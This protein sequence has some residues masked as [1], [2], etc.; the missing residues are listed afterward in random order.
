[1]KNTGS[2]RWSRLDNAAKIFPANSRA[3]DSKVFRFFCELREPV[4]PLA[5]QSALDGTVRE[6]PFYCSVMKR[7]LFWNYLEESL[8]RPAVSEENTPPCLSLYYPD[9]KGLLF[10]VSYYGKRI[11]LEIY[12]VLTDGTGALQFLCTLVHRYLLEKHAGDF[13]GVPPKLAYT[14]SQSQLWDD[15]F[16]K[17]YEKPPLSKPSLTRSAYHLRGERQ[18]EDR[19]SVVE[20][21]MP[22]DALLALARSRGATLTEFLTAVLIRAIYGQMRLRDRGRPVVI[23]VPV[24]LRNFLPSES[25][26][27]FFTTISVDYDFSRR[28]EKLDA[29]V[30]HVHKSFREKL[31]E[32]RLHERV[33]ML[34]FLEHNIPLRLVPLLLKD[35]VLFAAARLADRQATASFSNVGKVT[36][37]EE[38]APYI[39]LFGAFTSPGKLQASVC[40]FQNRYVISF[41]GPLRGHDVERVFFRSLARMGI[42]V[43]IAANPPYGE[44]VVTVCAIVKCAGWG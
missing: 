10:R 2:P 8:L 11:N 41:A 44:L 42:D 23:T 30:A 4:D 9:R 12:H 37:P 14:A 33:N 18:P 38:M 15:S 39:H 26:R 20:G 21:H 1:M 24:N 28:P 17:Y 34:G 7:G 5:L 3:G 25:A 22:V 40:S 19:L 13:A 29:V 36:M 43:E 32:R 16:Q 35:R 31:E 27:N 6:F